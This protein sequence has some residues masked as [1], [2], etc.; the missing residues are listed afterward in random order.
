MKLIVGLGNPG[1]EYA[2]NRHN[3]GF[4]LIRRLAREHSIR[5]DSKKAKAR[6]GAGRIADT[7]VVL[8][9]P[10]T[11]MNAS[12]EAVAPLM[13]RLNV[14]PEDLIVAHDDM[15]LPLGTIRIQKGRGA[16]GHKGAASI[17]SALG[18]QDFIRLRIGIGRPDTQ[19]TP[20]DED[21]I[22]GFVLS[23]FAEDEKAALNTALD[24]A[25]QAVGTLLT[26]GLEAA[27]N[28]HN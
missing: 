9:R 16:G 24:K 11:Y 19:N 1:R 2:A 7:E 25:V 26:E 21:S 8:A 15:D 23:D 28:R 27:M 13:K 5:L 20:P 3:A 10:Q 4:Q 17:I 12:G 22:I 6:I 18:G 14:P